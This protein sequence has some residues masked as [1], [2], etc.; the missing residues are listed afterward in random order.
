MFTRNIPSLSSE[1]L[2]DFLDDPAEAEA[3][4]SR[5]SPEKTRTL[6]TGQKCISSGASNSN[7]EV[8]PSAKN[9]SKNK[10]IVS[11][12]GVNIKPSKYEDFEREAERIGECRT[13]KSLSPLITKPLILFILAKLF[14]KRDLFFTALSMLKIVL[15]I[16]WISELVHM[17]H[18]K[19]MQQTTR[20][21]F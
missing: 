9:V 7:D 14:M 3:L 11:G 8:A 1:V 17:L 2:T 15:L 16:F 10:E 19:Q 21:C 20:K 13:V 6:T 18:Q 12:Q 5:F 4:I